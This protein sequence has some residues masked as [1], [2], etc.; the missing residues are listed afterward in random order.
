MAL[1][2]PLGGLDEGFTGRLS[3]GPFSE[4]LML[5]RFIAP[6]V[7]FS[8]KKV[9]CAEGVLDRRVIYPK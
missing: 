9:Y 4:G 8:E 7:Y 2:K 6:K 1:T 5:R 3:E